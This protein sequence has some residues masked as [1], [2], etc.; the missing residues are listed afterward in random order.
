V[1]GFARFLEIFKEDG[2]NLNAKSANGQRFI[3]Y[4]ADN[5]SQCEYIEV[6]AA[7]GAERP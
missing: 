1:E 7:A 3:E 4:I 5:E 2:R 6:M